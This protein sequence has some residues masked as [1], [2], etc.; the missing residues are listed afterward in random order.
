M[1]FLRNVWQ[2]VKN[3]TYM[4]ITLGSA[5]DGMVVSGLSTFGPKYI[6]AQFGYSASYRYET[7]FFLLTLTKVKVSI[8]HSEKKSTQKDPYF[9]V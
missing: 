2:L 8:P 1:P 9:W 3:P 7:N 5:F 6:Q 4:F